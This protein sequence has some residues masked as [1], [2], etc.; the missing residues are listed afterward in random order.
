MGQEISYFLLNIQARCFVFLE[1]KGPSKVVFQKWFVIFCAIFVFAVKIAAKV[2][3]INCQNEI[4][5]DGIFVTVY[6]ST[7]DYKEI[8]YKGKVI[9]EYLF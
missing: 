5:T 6:Y 8:A 3:R 4:H 1:L 7:F 9:F 2:N